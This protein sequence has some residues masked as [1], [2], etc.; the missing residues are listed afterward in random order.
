MA[1]LDRVLQTATDRPGDDRAMLRAIMEPTLAAALGRDAIA[2]PAFFGLVDAVV[3]TLL[4][5]PDAMRLLGE[6]RAELVRKVG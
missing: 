1:A 2:D 6:A 4:A 5:S 3:D